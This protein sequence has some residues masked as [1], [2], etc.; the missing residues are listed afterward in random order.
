MKTA[1]IVSAVVMLVLSGVVFMSTRDLPYWADFAPGSAFAPFWVAATGAALSISLLVGALRRQT[2]PP[3]DWPDRKGF[4]RVV[5][6][7]AGLWAVIALAPILGLIATAVL[8]MLFLL[9][10]VER[11]RLLPSLFTTAI[12]TALVYGVFAAWLGI[13]FPKGML[14]I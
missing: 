2:N 11:R 6:T 13:A 1:D 5:L 14:G 7:A 8:F 9:I 4:Q 10:V 12:T 3:V